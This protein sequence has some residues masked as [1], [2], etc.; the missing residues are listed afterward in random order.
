MTHPD[1]KAN[2]CDI[3]LAHLGGWNPDL[4]PWAGIVGAAGKGKSRCM[5]VHA[6]RMARA[7][8]R[9]H[10][11]KAGALA[12]LHSA[13]YSDKA[14]S[15]RDAWSYLRDMQTAD[16][17]IIDDIWKGLTVQYLQ[18]LFHLLEDRQSECKTILWSGNT[19]PD[20][21]QSICKETIPTDLLEPLTSRITGQSSILTI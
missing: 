19:H 4:H 16:V 18:T 17:L 11:V 8:R 14:G 1:W 12:W 6:H 20:D 10:W 2:R 13:R 3:Q 15:G 5:A 9:L 7:G 21:L